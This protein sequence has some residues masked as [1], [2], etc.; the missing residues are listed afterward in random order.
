MSISVKTDNFKDNN[1][2][3]FYKK[4]LEALISNNLDKIDSLKEYLFCRK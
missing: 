4:D 3:S 1:N 2:I